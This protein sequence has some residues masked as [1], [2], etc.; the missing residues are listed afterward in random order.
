MFNVYKHD[1]YTSIGLRITF[2]RNSINL[3]I[4]NPVFGVGTGGFV[5]KYA[6][7]KTTPA[8]LTKNPHNEYIYIAVQFGVIGLAIL[9]LFFG[10]PVWNGE[11]LPA[12]YRDI[13]Q[14]MILAIMTGCLANSWLLDTTPGH[15]YAYFMVLAFAAWSR[16]KDLCK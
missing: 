10:I 12:K 2:L 8:T 5:H 7:I 9:L 1:D 15:C 13:S 3:F 4:A 14:G 6:A 11:M 16:T